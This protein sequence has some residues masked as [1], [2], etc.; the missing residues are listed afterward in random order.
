MASGLK[1]CVDISL[2][3]STIFDSLHNHAK[4]DD[5]TAVGV[6]QFVLDHASDFSPAK[7]KKVAKLFDGYG[8]HSL[9]S[10]L[11]G[12]G[13]RTFNCS[14]LSSLIMCV[15][16]FACVEVAGLSEQM[17]NPVDLLNRFSPQIQSSILRSL[18]LPVTSERLHGMCVCMK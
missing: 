6:P 11:K 15:P 9:A 13:K 1:K 4:L 18:S 12:E 3:P 5:P 8:Y 7:V 10:S 16:M 2:V 14:L 17:R